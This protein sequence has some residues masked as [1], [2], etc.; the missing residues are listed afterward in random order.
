MAQAR[1]ILAIDQGTTSTRSIVFDAQAK[2]VAVAQTE[3]P[4]HYPNPGW[5]EH[6][7]E[8]IWRDVLA[9]AREAIDKS[10]VGVAGIAAIGITNQ[11]ETVVVWDRATGVPIHRAIVWQ[12][13]RT[14]ERCAQLKADGAE[15]EVRAR[16]GLLLDPYFLGTELAW[17]LDNFA[18]SRARAE[19]G[20]LAFGTIDSFLLWRLTGGKVHAT[21][22]TN[23]SRT[24][25]W[26]IREGRWDDE[27]CRLIGVPR[28]ILPEVH[29][30]AYV[31]GTT[32]P[33]LFGAPIPIAGIAGD[34]QAA[35]FGQA[36]FAKGMAKS[37]Y[38]TGCFM[39]LN[40]GTEAI[41]SENRLLTTPAYRLGGETTFALE[42]S[43][44]VA[45][46][47]VK[48][49]R[50]GIGVITRASETND[51]AT[52][53][54]DSHGVYMVPAFVGLGAPRWDPDA[55]AAIFGLTL[56]ATQA[57]LAR[58]A[59]EAVGYQT[60]D[61]VEAMVADGSTRP[62]AM[63]VDGGM[64][65]NDWLCGFLADLLEIP[66]ERPHD[67]E[68]TARGAAFHAGLATGLWSGLPELETLWSRE[69]IFE[70]HMTA[71]K[72]APLVAGWRDALRRTLSAPG[73]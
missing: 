22:V 20:E 29:D 46:A 16:T 58:A 18:C 6:D 63:R 10:K 37:T 21:D 66:V 56:G 42:G 14:A 65:A 61:L 26:N 54:P 7:A 71:E 30:N 47:A 40:T 41:A 33:D 15:A 28:A 11:R 35:L 17:M 69:A 38:G 25:L 31:Y 70:P 32:V 53:V 43:I 4:Q 8:D 3:F 52:Q 27:M 45:G 24:L 72:R 1:H 9:T 39:L 23:A 5:V 44:F 48:W 55:R 36:C 62:A 19:K 34:Q 60:L 57:H 50:D 64:A 51:M 12:D 68:T 67:L 13:R 59:L 73:A 49:L 2:R